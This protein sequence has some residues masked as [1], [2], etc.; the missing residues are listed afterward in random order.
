VPRSHEDRSHGRR[1]PRRSA[2][3]ITRA[4][5]IPT[6]GIVAGVECDGQVLV[7]HDELGLGGQRQG[8]KVPKYVE[9]YADLGH[10][11][12]KALEAYV[13]DAQAGR[14]PEPRQTYAM[15]NTDR[16]RFETDHHR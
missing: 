1:R 15:L 7:W 11:I 16:E 3:S 4:L 10:E 5:T 6:I 12:V 14:F 8:F 13:A 9:Q 2:G